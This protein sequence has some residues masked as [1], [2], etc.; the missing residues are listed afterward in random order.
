MIDLLQQ[1]LKSERYYER[2][3]ESTR[4][5][6]RHSLPF[7]G[8]WSSDSKSEEDSNFH[9]SLLLISLD[10]GDLVRWW[11][12]SESKL[13][14]TSP[15]IQNEILEIVGLQILR[16][17][18]QLHIRKMADVSN[19]EQLVFCVRWVDQKLIPHKQFLGMHLKNTS[20][21]EIGFVIKDIFMR[22]NFEMGNA[23]GQCYDGAYAMAGSKSEVATQLK[24]LNGKCLFAHC[25]G[26]ALN[27]ALGNFI[28]DLSNLK[29]MFSVAYKICKLLKKSPKRN[30]KLD[31]DTRMDQQDIVILIHIKRHQEI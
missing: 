24:S 22:M 25:Y 9:K 5:F 14:Y 31:Q 28:R 23:W 1:Q 27:F 8:K 17:I 19:K 15:Q 10:D 2:K 20:A 3:L 7:R 29:E 30:T 12:N 4:F 11:L 18:A 13:K 21:T 16:E 6:A 26:N